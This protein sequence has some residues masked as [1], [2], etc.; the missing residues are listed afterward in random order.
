MPI[1]SDTDLAEMYA[2]YLQS[3]KRIHLDTCKDILLIRV[4]SGIPPNLK[5][6]F[7]T[8]IRT[9][10]C[11]HDISIMLPTSFDADERIYYQ[12][13]SVS[14][15]EI[16]TNTYV[17]TEIGIKIGA[18]ISVSTWRQ[19]HRIWLRLDYYPPIMNPEEEEVI[20][21]DDDDMPPLEV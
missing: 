6:R 17:L 12:S 5:D 19:D 2:A 7:L 21:L 15:D 9:A 10:T 16:F 3:V 1:L 20:D 11:E 13:R 4:M 18:N 8:A 14:V